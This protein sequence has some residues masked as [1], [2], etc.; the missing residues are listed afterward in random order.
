MIAA[1][2]AGERNSGVLFAPLSCANERFT[3]VAPCCTAH[4]IPSATVVD[5]PDPSGPRTRTGMIFALG[6]T[7]ATPIEFPVTAAMMPAIKV[8]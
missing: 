5:E 2:T 6:A 7:D 3:T 8:P 1:S 4:V